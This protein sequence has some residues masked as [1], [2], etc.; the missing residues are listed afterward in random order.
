MTQP[1]QFAQFLMATFFKPT[2]KKNKQQFQCK[3]TDLDLHG[4]GVGHWQ[5][6]PVFVSGALPDE[7]V[8][9]SADMP[10]KGPIKAELK[11]ILQPSANR[12][13]PVCRHYHVCGGCKLQH[14]KP[15]LQ[16]EF[17]QKALS[18]LLFK[19]GIEPEAWA[20]PIYSPSEIGYR[21]K[22][23]LAVDARNKVKLGFRHFSEQSILNISECH[24][25]HPTLQPLLQPIQ[26]LIS[27]LIERKAIGHVE[28]FVERQHPAI[29]LH[30]QG[31]WPA[32]DQQR[33]ESWCLQYQVRLLTKDAQLTY[34]L[35]D[36]TI[37]LSYRRDSFVQSN[38]VVNQRMVKQALDWLDLTGDERVFDLF[39]GI[40]NFTLPLA[41]KCAHVIGVEGV[42]YMVELASQNARNNGIDNADFVHADL[43]E[44]LDL[45]PWWQTADAVLLDPA[46]AGAEQVV[47]QL[48]FTR[49]PKVL[50]VSC[51]PTTLVRDAA[52]LARQGYKIAQAGV[53]DMFPHT[54]HLESMILFSK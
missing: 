54:H 6:R 13:T 52:I 30:R 35:D 11:S 41:R 10:R 22:A 33:I 19:H 28:L 36:G 3:L 26:K 8:S 50:Y 34:P 7:L 32:A 42:S 27:E 9:L 38:L 39:C 46:R 12:V 29:W 17:K 45:Q 40:G 47:K 51:N 5:Q 25:L 20:L 4:Q 24:V 23:R 15:N 16:I 31:D 18:R 21:T 37:E 14:L 53:M 2:K 1:V 43:N 49:A 48:H 44:R